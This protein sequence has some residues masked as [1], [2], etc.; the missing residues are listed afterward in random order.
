MP[1]RIAKLN[2][3]HAVAFVKGKT[4]ILTFEKDGT[5][6]YGSVHD[7]YN[8]YEN[9]RVATEKSTE[10][11]TKA[12]MRHKARRSYP[13]GIVFAPQGGPDGAYNHWQGFAVEPD[14]SSSCARFLDHLRDNIC[15][16]DDNAYQWVIRWFAHMVQRPWE[17][18]GTALVLKGR[19]GAGK[20]TIGDYVGGL[21]PHHHN[22]EPRTSGR[23]LQRASGKDPAAA[24][25]RRLLGRRQKGRREL[26][27]LITSEQVMIESKGIN[28]F[29]V[30]SVLRIIISSNEDWIVPATFDE[31]RFCVLNVADT[32]AR[33]TVY[34]AKL[35]EE[36]HHGGRAALLHHL[37]DLDLTGFDVRNP[38]MTTGLRDQK[39]ASLRRIEQWLFEILSSGRAPGDS[40]FEDVE[41]SWEDASIKVAVDDFRLNYEDWLRRRR[42]AGDPLNASRFG[43]RAKSFQRSPAFTPRSAISGS[44]IM[45]FPAWLNAAPNSKN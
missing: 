29:Q 23:P 36:M 1:K 6:S 25:R 18:P 35:R 27:H 19:K 4:V 26:K 41:L 34:F 42:F 22:C 9:D 37:L 7:V 16:G 28:A 20:D 31:R 21:F 13:N 17:K 12:W 39:I 30:A 43:V 11:V 14:P 45:L 3:N 24:C 15:A 32:R 10:P 44:G 5:T 38:P 2:K 40:M 33:D 8:Y